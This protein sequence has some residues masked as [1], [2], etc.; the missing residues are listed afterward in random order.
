MND[1]VNL[2]YN[3]QN[4]VFCHGCRNLEYKLLKLVVYDKTDTFI[5]KADNGLCKEDVAFKSIDCTGILSLQGEK[6]MCKSC[7]LVDPILRVQL[8]R[9]KSLLSNDH[10]G[11]I[12]QRDQ[13]VKAPQTGD[14]LI[15]NRLYPCI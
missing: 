1:I 8:T 3:I 13:K 15:C 5:G 6:Q 2:S 9:C 11:Q 7:Q 4:G 14:T 10:V 12:M